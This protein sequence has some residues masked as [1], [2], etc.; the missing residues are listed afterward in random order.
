VT[1]TTRTA[2]ARSG[3]AVRSPGVVAPRSAKPYVRPRPVPQI[4][5]IGVVV[6]AAIGFVTAFL[7]ALAAGSDV[8]SGLLATFVIFGI[9]APILRRMF[10]GEEANMRTLMLSALV[11]KCA[12]AFF[13]YAVAFELYD[14]V[15]DAEHYHRAGAEF[16]KAFRH[17]NFDLGPGTLVGTR[18]VEVAT[19]WLYAVVGTSRVVGFLAFSWVGYWGLVWFYKACKTAVPDGNH[20][21]YAFLV[22]LLPSMLFWPS[23]IGKEAWMVGTIGLATYGVARYLAHQR[24]ALVR[25]GLGLWGAS[26]V[27]P[28]VVLLILAGLAVAV[29]FRPRAEAGRGLGHAFQPILRIV[30]VAAIAVGFSAAMGSSEQRFGV[31]QERRASS[32]AGVRDYTNEKSS[33]HGNSTF[34]AQPVNS[35]LD[36]PGGF[37]SVLFRPFPWEGKSA[38][39]LLSGLEGS[40][41][42]GAVLWRWR[43]IWGALKRWRSLPYVALSATFIVGF[44]WAFSSFGNFGLLVRQRVQVYPFLLALLCL[45]TI[46]PLA[47]RPIRRPPPRRPLRRSA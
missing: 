14:G 24:G 29:V 22:L 39:M 13:Q 35:P 33:E 30:V 34:E 16:A 28:H 1:A 15:A 26:M 43:S 42:L 41:L 6:F 19:G 31:G 11:L 8:W 45:P 3:L 37:I 27:R 44:V 38:Q 5:G 47:K 2:T 12:G 23:A 25:I 20:K 9:S 46:A 36:F 7:V 10:S 32:L 17:G 4:G 18:F 40:A 21:I